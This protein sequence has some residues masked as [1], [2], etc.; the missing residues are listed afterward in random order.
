M[1]V[2]KKLGSN[3]DLIITKP[4]KGNGVV[5][6]NESDYERK[7]KNLLQDFTKLTTNDE[8]WMSLVFKYQDKVSYFVDNLFKSGIISEDEKKKLLR[9]RVPGLE[10]RSE[11]QKYIS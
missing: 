1:S 6:L 2:T 4:D 8:S 3:K 5:L 9:R 7:M 10:I 11:C